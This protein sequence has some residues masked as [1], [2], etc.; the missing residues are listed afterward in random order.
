VLDNLALKMEALY[1]S[2]TLMPTF[3]ST[4]RHN[5]EDR[6]GHVNAM[7]TS[8]SVEYFLFVCFLFLCYSVFPI[9]LSNLLLFYFTRHSLSVVLSVKPC[10]PFLHTL[11]YHLQLAEIVDC[12]NLSS[13]CHF[14][15]F[16]PSFL[17]ISFTP[18]RRFSSGLSC[19][20]R[21]FCL[22]QNLD[23]CVK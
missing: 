20:L 4:R 23:I 5:P 10:M 16:P 12:L 6:S 22:C 11:R 14:H 2:E 3:N 7:R 18:F 8:N 9:L 19:I 21:S 13:S 15:S 17:F 1:S